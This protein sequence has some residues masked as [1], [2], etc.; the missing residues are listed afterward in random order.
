MAFTP[1]FQRVFGKPNISPTE[2]KRKD[3]LSMMKKDKIA[4]PQQTKNMNMAIMSPGQPN[5]SVG[6]PKMSSATNQ[7]NAIMSQGQPT[8]AQNAAGV[9]TADKPTTSAP[10]PEPMNKGGVMGEVQRQNEE[11]AR[12][13]ALSR[14]N[15][16]NTPPDT[17]IANATQTSDLTS[18]TQTTQQAQPSESEMALKALRERYAGTLSPSE[19]ERRLQDELELFRQSAQLGI[20]GLEGQGRG[21]PLDLIRGQQRQLGEQAGIQEQTMLQRLANA[22]AARLG[23]QQAA[24]TELGFAREDLANEQAQAQKDFNTVEFGGKLYS[25]DPASGQLQE[26]AQAPLSAGG[27]QFT[28]SPNQLRFDAQGNLI[29]SGLSEPENAT[30][31]TV[32]E[33]GGRD[34][35]WNPTTGQWEV[36]DFEKAADPTLV[37]GIADKIKLIDGLLTS[38]G[39]AGSVGPYGI[40]RWTP[41]TADKADRQKFAGDVNRLISEETIGSLLDLKAQGGTLGA[42]SDQE[43]IMLQNAA[44]SIGSWM[45]RDKNGNPTGKFEVS[46]KDFIAELNR[47]KELAGIALQRALGDSVQTQPSIYSQ[48]DL[49]YLR[50]AGIDVD[51]DPQFRSEP[52]NNDL[53][54]SVN[55][56]GDFKDYFGDI[57]GLNGSPYWDKG[58]DIDLKKGDPLPSPVSGEVIFVGQNGGFGNQIKIRTTQGNEVWLSHLDD[59]NVKQGDRITKG[60]FVGKG[61]NSGSVIPGPGGDGSHL[62]LTVKQSDGT[63][64]PPRE[65]ARRL[66]YTV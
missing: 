26:L 11:A 22:Q 29:A 59:F 23:E 60:Q 1:L 66:G 51:N 53:S 46:E 35:Q 64:I 34:M 54:M 61:G 6:Q 5:M 31:P 55:G 12:R 37:A 40:S 42:L 10:T 47:I 33:I 20:S 39:M 43:R 62:D 30:V 21:I 38:P 15:A 50:A 58:L 3:R 65:I 14:M 4:S 25:F 45:Q 44:T 28:L 24:L 18:P 49:D 19:E 9:T 32:R 36:I 63:F 16:Q 7:S 56:S 17:T 57:T 27:D 13:L 52:F 8:K 2:Q 48:E 41:F